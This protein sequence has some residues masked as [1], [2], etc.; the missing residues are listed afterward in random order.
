MLMHRSQHLADLRIQGR[1]LCAFSI[2]ECLP[3]SNS[4]TTWRLNAS[5]YLIAVLSMTS[6]SL[7]HVTTYFRTRP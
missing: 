3:R 7:G 2:E 5:L 6:F 4:S 1:K